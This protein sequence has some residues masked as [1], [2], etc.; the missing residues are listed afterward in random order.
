MHRRVDME[1]E[2]IEVL[3][4][5]IE[6]LRRLSRRQPDPWIA[7]KDPEADNTYMLFAANLNV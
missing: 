4:I 3:K 1:W 2:W 7:V 5:T 6:T